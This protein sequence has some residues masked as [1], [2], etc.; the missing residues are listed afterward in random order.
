MTRPLSILVLG[1]GRVG[2]Q[3]AT[4]AASAGHSVA[5]VDRQQRSF[6]RL[7]VAFAG[8][9]WLGD[10]MDKEVLEAAGVAGCDAVAAVMYGDNSNIVAARMAKETYAVR[11]VVA[12]IKDPRRAEIYRR[13]GIPTVAP[14]TWAAEQVLRRLYGGE[15]W[16]DWTHPS[17]ETH[18][19]ERALP[20][21]WAGRPLDPFLASPDGYRLVMVTRDGVPSF[22]VPGVV[23]QEGDLLHVL[24]QVDGAGALAL[25][26]AEGPA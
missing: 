24:V 11:S 13:L 16:V 6:G 15:T 1:C 22:A 9:T 25:D 20:S 10:G 26:L 14:V 8:R 2:A 4:D 5:V 12:R 23:G 18:L 7:P 21:G 19:I 17:G 3:I